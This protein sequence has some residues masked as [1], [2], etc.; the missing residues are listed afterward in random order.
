MTEKQK[1]MINAY[2]PNPPDPSLVQGEYYV[3]DTADRPIKVRIATIAP[4]G[5][6][7]IYQVFTPSGRMVHGSYECDGDLLG[8]SWYCMSA[9]Y[10]NKQDCKDC[11]H[12]LYDSWEELREIQVKELTVTQKTI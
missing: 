3:L 7:T 9:L 8:G 1:R 4:K 10:D 11:T 5:E 6:S 2:L 12:L